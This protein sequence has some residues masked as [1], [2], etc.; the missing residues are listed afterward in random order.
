MNFDYTKGQINK[1]NEGKS[2][3]IKLS[4]SEVFTYESGKYTYQKGFKTPEIVAYVQDV[5][6]DDYVV[7]AAPSGLK[8]M[9]TVLIKKNNNIKSKSQKNNQAENID[10]DLVDTIVDIKAEGLLDDKDII[11]TFTEDG[12]YSKEQVQAALDFINK[13]TENESPTATTEQAEFTPN[14]K[15][16][17][18]FEKILETTSGATRNKNIAEAVKINPKIQEIMDNFDEL[19]KQL[20]ASVELTEDCSW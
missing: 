16:I 13:P 15:D 8:Q 14:A 10:Q 11:D 9:A 4:D 5:L 3:N 20:M 2:K 18:A 12:E 6:G 1:I 19:K 17:K 7:S